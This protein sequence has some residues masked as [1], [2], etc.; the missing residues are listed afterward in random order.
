M[1]KACARRPGAAA[2]V[3]R[4]R[5]ERRTL[6]AGAAGELAG[7][8]RLR[9]GL[10][11]HAHSLCAMLTSVL[12][13]RRRF[14]SR[15]HQPLCMLL[16]MLSTLARCHRHA[17]ALVGEGP[18]PRL[19]ATGGHQALGFP[20]DLRKSCCRMCEAVATLLRIHQPH[21]LCPTSATIL[22]VCCDMI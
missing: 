22:Y 13:V 19:P 20:R 3:K 11:A 1:T 7:A 21:P 16:R 2:N 10:R 9:Q 4:R 6:L 12:F 18:L 17:A 5:R 14:R 15:R 8:T